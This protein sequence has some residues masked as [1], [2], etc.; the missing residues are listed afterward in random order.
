LREH[1]RGLSTRAMKAQMVDLKESIAEA[2]EQ[3]LAHRDENET[4]HSR[5]VPHS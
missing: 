4:V 2:R 5:H 3:A 1:G